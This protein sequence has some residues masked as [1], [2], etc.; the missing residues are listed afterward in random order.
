M[1]LPRW[2][3]LV[4]APADWHWQ[5]SRL[6]APD[7]PRASP[8]G[9]VLRRFVVRNLYATQNSSPAV[10]AALARCLHVLRDGEF[11][12]DLGG[13]ARRL[14]ARLVN[15]DLADLPQVDI[16]AP[17]EKLPFRDA[18]LGLVVAQEV[19]EHLPDPHAT[20]AEIARVLR[21]GGIVYVQTPWMLGWHSGPQD[22]WRFSREG[23]AALFGPAFCVQ[24]VAASLG[25]GSGF[26]RVAVEYCAITAGAILAPLYLPAKA[27]AALLLIPFRW[28]DLLSA[29]SDQ[30]HRIAGGFYA[31][32]RRR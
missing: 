24:E 9:G 4:D 29:R 18:S 21:P 12:L 14:D 19:F 8:Q 11:G 5:G 3:A 7:A 17:A 13:G 23:M 22:F 2:A 31:I 28:A 6:V 25:H 16:V 20:L 10:R 32:A 30:A 1:T 15:L 26:Y 27:A